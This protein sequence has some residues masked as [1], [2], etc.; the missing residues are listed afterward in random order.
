MGDGVT[1]AITGDEVVI[2][3]EGLNVTGLSVATGS[4]SI[5][6]RG[7]GLAGVVGA[8]VVTGDKGIAVVGIVVLP[9]LGVGIGSDDESPPPLPVML[10][11]TTPET[12]I[13][14]I[15]AHAMAV[16]QGNIF[17]S[18]SRLICVG[19]VSSLWLL[20]LLSLLL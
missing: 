3:L 10:K 14:V 9:M 5:A 18:Y 16:F 20:L 8:G 13:T 4:A 17:C 19:A 6:G 7:A 11:A 2:L 15:E 12:T 1:G